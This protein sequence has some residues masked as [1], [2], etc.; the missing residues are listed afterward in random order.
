MKKNMLFVL[1]IMVICSLFN[2][3]YA[4]DPHVNGQAV[5]YEPKIQPAELNAYTVGYAFNWGTPYETVNDFLVQVPNLTWHETTL[6]KI[7]VSIQDAFEHFYFS[8]QNEQLY[9]IK[10]LH[11]SS[12]NKN[13]D[14]PG[15]MEKFIAEYN[16][17]GLETY[18]GNEKFNSFAENNPETVIVADQDTVYRVYPHEVDENGG[19][20]PYAAIH[21]LDRSYSEL[22]SNTESRNDKSVS[23]PGGTENEEPKAELNPEPNIT[24]DEF[25]NTLFGYAFDWGTSYDTVLDF[26]S[27][28]SGFELKKGS[29]YISIATKSSNSAPEY[30]K[31]EFSD[32]KLITVSG[33]LYTMCWGSAVPSSLAG[34]TNALKTVYG[35]QNLEAYTKNGKMN[36]QANRTEASFIAADDY[37]IY[38]LFNNIRSGNSLSSVDFVFTDKHKSETGVS[39]ADA[40]IGRPGKEYTEKSSTAV[41]EQSGIAKGT[42]EPSAAPSIKTTLVGNC[43]YGTHL[44]AGDK[45][46]IVNISAL[47]MY[48]APGK[49]PVEGLN[50]F[51]GKE[52]TI[53]DGPHCVNGSIWWKINF[54]GYTG[55]AAEMSADGIYYMQ[56]K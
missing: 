54:L 47:R 44:A 30:Y 9:E 36:A 42:A 52:F 15:F 40:G 24:P 55:W 31:F 46:E 48:S 53:T 35:L 33:S 29:S 13:A 14:L 8:F 49:N 50:A 22:Q 1:I 7:Y 3:V 20:I 27:Q 21:L 45:A 16:L 11:L 12:N 28:L 5:S 6:E 43:L 34:I 2:C 56:K 32:E 10:C 19:Y 25:S 37:T 18:T 51:P 39:S 23:D 4:S 38:G 17:S 26:L 41:A